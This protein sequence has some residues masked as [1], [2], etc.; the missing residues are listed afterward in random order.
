[1]GPPPDDVVSVT[2]ADGTTTTFS[3]DPGSGAVASSTDPAGGQT[4]FGYDQ[5][6]QQ[7]WTVSGE[8]NKAGGSPVGYRQVSVVDA[9]GSTLVTGTP[10]AHGVA[11]GF[12]RSTPSGLGSAATGEAWTTLSGGWVSSGGVASATSPGLVTVDAP[13]LP[14]DG[15]AV[16]SV[17]PG[18]ATGPVGVAFRVQDTNN[19]WAA[20]TDDG[21][22]E[23]VK[24]IGGVSTTVTSIPDAGFTAGDRIA[25]YATDTE[26]AVGRN[27]T[28]LFS[29][30]DAALGT[31]SGVGLF[32]GAAGPVSGGFLVGRLAGGDHPG[33]RR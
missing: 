12:I 28:G 3:Y 26:V 14:A 11:D 15:Q 6:G 8:G 9:A 25:V 1:M 27:E 18:G 22:L 20:F 31:A 13:V 7:V 23:V 24:V 19:Y 29:V 5:V 17:L 10:E 30:S 2:G 32:T 21:A 33:A 4:T 16:I